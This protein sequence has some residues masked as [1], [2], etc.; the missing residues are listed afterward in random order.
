MFSIGREGW[1]RAG[2]ELGIVFLGVLVALLVDGWNESRIE[3]GIERDYIL[4]I[5]EDVRDDRRELA[6]LASALDAKRLAIRKL[7]SG[8]AE[9]ESLSDRQ[10]IAT[11]VQAS[12]AG[13]GVLR[14]N[15]TTFEDLRSTGN[16]GLISDPGLR[17][18]VVSYYE[19]WRFNAAR[20][21]A[22]RST[23]PAAI[24]ALLPSGAYS[25]DVFFDAPS[26]SVPSDFSRSAVLT[27]LGGERARSSLRGEANY[28]RFFRSVVRDLDE[29]AQA[30]SDA[31]GAGRS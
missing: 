6:A 12:A 25:P 14:G 16:L 19:S 22:R 31:V 20:V 2:F 21:D 4:R 11:L 8:P 23:L 18:Q 13:F 24:Y 26:D 9:V 10:L 17:A 5:S 1:R 27:F 30:L 15:S 3:R 28:A 29:Q 7:L